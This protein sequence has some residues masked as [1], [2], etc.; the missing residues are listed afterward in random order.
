MVALA[1]S[2]FSRDK[3]DGGSAHITLRTSET[4][5]IA[6][7]NWDAFSAKFS[8]NKQNA[9]ERLC[10]LL[11]CKEFGK[12]TGV[13]RF[14]KIEAALHAVVLEEKE[15]LARGRVERTFA[16]RLKPIFEGN[17]VRVDSH[18]NKHGLAAK[19]LNRKIIELDIAIHQRGID[20]HNL[21][22]I[23]I[24]TNNAPTRDDI[25]KLEGLTGALGGYGYGLGLYIAVGINEKAGEILAIEWYQNG[26]LVA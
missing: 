4:D 10:Y 3:I 23:E 22:A 14:R 2:A 19:Y 21:V 20:E 15:H 1:Y 16:N 24:E 18:Y 11:F 5:M 7:I 13:F 17:G 8:T 26:S 25:W 9:F 6:E 12:S